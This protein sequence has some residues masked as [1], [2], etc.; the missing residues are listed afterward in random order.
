VKSLLKLIAGGT[1]VFMLLAVGQEWDFFKTAW[2]G[3]DEPV[4][5]PPEVDRKEV[6]ESLRRTLIVIGHLY[7]S[8]GDRRFAER[9]AIS[10][11]ILDEVIEDV[12]YLG[13][14]HLVQ[15][16]TLTDLEILELD[17]LSA[18]RVELRTREQWLVRVLSTTSQLAIGPAQSHVSHGRYLLSRGGKGWSVAAW[19][20]VSPASPSDGPAGP[21]GSRD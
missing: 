6:E 5:A 10:S 14:Q 12:R 20:M 19:E 15:E 16:Q 13:R 8:G 7:G 1:A 21:Q 18:D 17:T 9:L 11:A 4:S 3:A 2:F